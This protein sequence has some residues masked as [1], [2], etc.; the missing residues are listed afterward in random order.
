MEKTNK[1]HSIPSGFPFLSVQPHLLQGSEPAGASS[2]GL[3]SVPLGRGCRAIF[4]FAEE[5]VLHLSGSEGL[6]MSLP[7][8][9][10]GVQEWWAS[11]NAPE[12]T[13]LADALGKRSQVEISAHFSTWHPSSA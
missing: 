13:T 9:H 12:K 2:F 10:G 7:S 11:K 6:V 5:R 8:D 1:T 4:R 3:Q